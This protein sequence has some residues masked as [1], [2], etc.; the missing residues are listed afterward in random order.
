MALPHGLFTDRQNVGRSVHPPLRGNVARLL[1]GTAGVTQ[2]CPGSENH[3]Q[4]PPRFFCGIDWADQDNAVAVIDTRTDVVHHRQ[5]AT[6]PDGLRD[7]FTLLSGL[8]ASHQHSRKKVPIAI[9]TNAGLLVYALR[10]RGQPVFQ[11]PPTDMAR[12]RKYR[13]AT[14]K[15]ADRSDAELL[16][17][18]LRDKWSQL[19]PLP[20]TSPTAAAITVL[21]RAQYRSQLLRE[22]LQ[23][24]LRRLLRQVHPVALIAWEG[25]DYGLRRAEARVVLEAGPTAEAAARLTQYRLSK[26]L[27]P[28]RLRL[29]DDEAYR[30]RDLFTQPVLRLPRDIEI[31]TAVEIRA[32]LAQ[33]NHACETTAHLTT[34]LT[35]AFLQHPHAPTYLS[36]PGCGPL[37]GARLLAELGDDPHRFASARGLRAYA[38]LAPLTWSSGNSRQV[39]HRY[40]CNRRLKAVCHQWAF[41]S[42]TRS[43]GAR[44]RYDQRRAA[45]DSYGGALRHVSSRLLTCL[46]HCLATG[47]TYD[48]R[49]AF[50][51][52]Q[53]LD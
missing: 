3:M 19:Q 45:G 6:S 16:A 8:L 10:T 26:I 50:T 43:P 25:R 30:L 39:T 2:P 7:L 31:A 35:D 49:R 11:I 32:L 1:G 9:E 40:V 36:F 29:V 38:G 37:G 52:R 34:K 41:S 24:K 5:I 21:A 48:E 46:H 22:Q 47:T 4:R 18:L 44:A 28:V 14:K 51:N 15:K 13:S 23:A 42:L 12:Y 20:D 27:A 33:F 53:Q 17:T